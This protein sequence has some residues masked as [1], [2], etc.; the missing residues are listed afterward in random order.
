MLLC[1]V[2]FVVCYVQTFDLYFIKGKTGDSDPLTQRLKGTILS[3][4][5][6]HPRTQWY[7]EGRDPVREGI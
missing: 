2:F 1:C 7:T 3:P 5:H 6:H 4:N